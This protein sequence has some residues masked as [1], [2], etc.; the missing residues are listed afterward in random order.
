MEVQ[1]KKYRSRVILAFIFIMMVQAACGC[2]INYTVDAFV[3]EDVNGNGTQDSGEPGIPNISFY[4][5][6]DTDSNGYDYGYRQMGDNHCPSASF[7][8]YFIQVTVP[9]GFTLT[10]KAYNE[11][12]NC[13]LLTDS[14]PTNF[15]RSYRV[16]IEEAQ[17]RELRIGL[18]PIFGFTKTPHPSTFS[19]AG[20]EISYTFLITNP[21]G[22]EITNT[23]ITD[24]KLGLTDFDCT[25]TIPGGQS[26]SCTGTYTTTD[27]DVAA[28]SITN[29]AT[30]TIFIGGTSLELEA[31]ATV[32]LVQTQEE[33]PAISGPVLSGQF[34][35]FCDPNHAINFRVADGTDTSLVSQEFTNGNLILTIAGQNVSSTCQLTPD[36]SVLGCRYPDNIQNYPTQVQLNYSGNTLIQFAFYGEICTQSTGGGG[37]GGGGETSGGSSIPAACQADPASFECGCALDPNSDPDCIPVP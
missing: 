2:S 4:R 25:G 36:Q 19:A 31:S 34:S 24:S 14:I 15:S 5:D 10:E 22:A 1:M 37:G 6:F 21:P 33:A 18:A 23:T 35:V 32:N 27:A 20:Q 3:Y 29:T 28:G 17:T 26:D 7:D 8:I 12:W 11:D 16:F 30:V 13:T 9:S